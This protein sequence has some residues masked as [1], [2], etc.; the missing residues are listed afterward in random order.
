[1]GLRQSITDRWRRLAGSAAGDRGE[2]PAPSAPDAAL[3]ALWRDLVAHWRSVEPEADGTPALTRATALEARVAAAEAA[4]DAALGEDLLA[5]VRELTLPPLVR[6]R[7]RIAELAGGSRSH[8]RAA[9]SHQLKLT[10][11]QDEIARCRGVIEQEC[12]RRGLQPAALPA[13]EGDLHDLL[14]QVF[15]AI[16]H[17]GSRRMQAAGAD[18][19]IG[20]IDRLIAAG[21]PAAVDAF[22]AWLR[23]PAARILALVQERNRYKR[24]LANH[25]LLP[26]E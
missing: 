1:M 19:I 6:L 23:Q 26:P 15:R 5:S 3:I 17:A 7:E 2:A 18:P 21:D 16:S 4:G 22:P 10:H 24:L 25:G 9:A 13:G 11:L 20:E 12:R 14:Y 8:Q